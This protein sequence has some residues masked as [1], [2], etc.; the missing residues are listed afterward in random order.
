MPLDA[1][2]RGA[3]KRAFTPDPARRRDIAQEITDEIIGLLEAGG[4]L[5][6][7]MPWKRSAGSLPLRHEG[8][9]YRGINVFML[10]LRAMSRGYTSPYWMSYRQAVELGGQV[11]KG[12]KAATVVYYGV[13][14]N[15]SADANPAPAASGEAHDGEGGDSR[16]RF[17]KWFPAFNADQVD[18]LPARYHPTHDDLDGGARPIADLAAIADAMITGLGVTYAEGGDRACYIRALD[19]IHLPDIRRFT[20]AERFY[21]TKFHEAAHATEHPKRLNI[22]YGVKSFGNESYAR[23]ELFALSRQSAPSSRTSFLT[24]R[25]LST[26]RPQRSHKAGGGRP[27]G[28]RRAGRRRESRALRPFLIGRVHGHAGLPVE[29]HR[30]G[31]SVG[32]RPRRRRARHPV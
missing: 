10:G 14:K 5:P 24:G 18:G 27:V 21:A 13:G 19:Q 23:G 22:D 17:L 29:D 4:E 9:P 30:A 12:E 31:A 2:R 7:R 16:Y 1:A 11:R 28:R 8:S 32:Q 26:G 25:R 6:W 3:R 15:R 20:D